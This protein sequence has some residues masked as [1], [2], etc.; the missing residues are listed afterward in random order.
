[1]KIQLNGKPHEATEAATVHD[2]LKQIGFG[3]RPVVVEINQEALLVRQYASTVLND[4][5]VMEVV[6]ITA[7]G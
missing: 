1:M 6:Q 5:D 7:G 3:D 4:G 2:V